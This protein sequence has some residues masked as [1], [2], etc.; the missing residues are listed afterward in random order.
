MHHAPPTRI[1]PGPRWGSL[2]AAADRLGV[3]PRTV[4][5]M[6]SAGELQGFRLGKRLLRV[7]MN[8]VDKLLHRVP[9]AS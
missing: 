8:E 3:H 5:R 6:I 7:D 1:E 4:R 2:E 9:A